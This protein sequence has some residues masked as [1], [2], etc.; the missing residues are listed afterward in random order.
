MLDLNTLETRG[1]KIAA[2]AEPLQG[3]EQCNEHQPSALHTFIRIRCIWIMQTREQCSEHQPSAFLL[4]AD[5]ISCV[6]TD[7]WG[8]QWTGNKTGQQWMPDL[9]VVS[10]PVTQ[11]THWW[12]LGQML[13][14]WWLAGDTAPVCRRYKQPGAQCS[15]LET[16]GC[17]LLR[18]GAAAAWRHH[19]LVF[20]RGHIR[21]YPHLHYSKGS[22][23]M[24]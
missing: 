11:C 7:K 8:V 18:A 22:K 12:T 15:D 1:Q 9:S 3:P 17:L 21:E 6:C 2:F 14:P 10:P 13:L 24:L 4:Y 20:S 16:A 19:D 23:E 5:R